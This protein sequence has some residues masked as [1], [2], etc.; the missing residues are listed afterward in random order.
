MKK[1]IYLL[2][3]LLLFVGCTPSE[4]QVKKIKNADYGNYPKDYESL[5]KKHYEYVLFDPESVRYKSIT[6]PKK[7]YLKDAPI[8]GGNPKLFGY[9]VNVC[10]NAKNRMGGYTGNKCENL[11]IRDSMVKPIV[12]N[13][14]H[15]EEW[16]K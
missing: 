16:Y 8:S 1:E 3:T 4:L 13:T 6:K 11:F 15:N 10:M 5:V 2:L 7:A 14:W 9:F 12:P